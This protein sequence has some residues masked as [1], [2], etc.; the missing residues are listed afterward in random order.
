[1]KYRS[2]LI[3]VLFLLILASLIVLKPDQ[4]GAQNTFLPN[5]NSLKNWHTLQWLRDGKFGIYTFENAFVFKI[6]RRNPF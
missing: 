5:W 3:P 2:S 1:M 6:V 4:A